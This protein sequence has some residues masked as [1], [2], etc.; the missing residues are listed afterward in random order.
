VA[1]CLNAKSGRVVWKKRLGGDYWAC[2]INAD[3]K[4]YFWF[5]RL[6]R[7][8]TKRLLAVIAS[9]DCGFAF[10]YDVN[11]RL[12]ARNTELVLQTLQQQ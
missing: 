12:D 1:S 11:V 4:N 7:S 8:Q 2:P 10:F 9:L 3:G 5:I 6:K